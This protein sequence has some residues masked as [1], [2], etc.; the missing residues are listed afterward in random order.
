[1]TKLRL[2]VALLALGLSCAAAAPARAQQL[3]PTALAAADG[4]VIQILNNAAAA[5]DNFDFNASIGLLQQG[6]A[7]IRQTNL[8]SRAA[9]D[10]YLLD[11][12]V[13]YAASGA[14]ADAVNAFVQAMLVDPN[15]RLHPNYATPAL[16]TL[17]QRARGLANPVA[18]RPAQVAPPAPR[19]TPTLVPQAPPAP[20][21][22]LPSLS[23]M[24]VGGYAPAPAPA[25][26]AP[27]APVVAP[28]QGLIEHMPPREARAREPLGISARIP[29][30]VPVAKVNLQFR[31]IGEPLF[32]AVELAPQ[33]DGVSFQGG[34]PG[35]SVV[36][37]GV[38]YY[39]EVLD[40]AGQLLTTSGSAAT[41]FRVALPATA[42]PAPVAR[43]TRPPQ[44]SSASKSRGSDWGALEED[45]RASGKAKNF[46]VAIGG[47]LG[48]G[49]ATGAPDVVTDV[50]LGSGIALT[51]GHISAELGYAI[52]DG[53]D[54]LPFARF[55]VVTLE[56][57]TEIEPLFGAKIRKYLSDTGKLDL[58]VEGGLG[59]GYVRHFVYVADKKT[60][61]TTSEGPF[62]A[63]G[64]GG[65]RFAFNG[66]SG[67]TAGGYLMGLAGDA[68]SV[69][70]DL[71]A[72]LYFRF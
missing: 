18:A 17:L 50:K 19:P 14:E 2:S 12:V 37:A 21:G 41:P 70:L 35:S 28:A 66:S 5:Y 13:R 72:L 23:A 67:L 29:V 55:Q 31:T 15:A 68:S 6:V 39:L 54:I 65:L 1:M 3:N 57:G 71:Q 59:Y 27:P 10:L 11:G 47:G 24:G 40:R 34:I 16:E 33:R 48:G 4:Q 7:I 22:T 38:E 42:A 45:D 61:V 43:A 64:G 51:P 30:T 36:G 20:A 46:S 63:G 44:S 25:P 60:Y 26:I 62:S 9:A 56:S 58:Y 52:A 32:R 49:L 8:R 69:Q 53:V